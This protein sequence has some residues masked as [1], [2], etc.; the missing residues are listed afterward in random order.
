MVTEGKQ[1]KSSRKSGR[2]ERGFEVRSLKQDLTS[3]KV[4][5]IIV[6]RAA[7]LSTIDQTKLT[8]ITYSLICKAGTSWVT[9]NLR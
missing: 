3:A 7:T 1:Q 6:S 5:T 2:K 4:L 8:N 9:K